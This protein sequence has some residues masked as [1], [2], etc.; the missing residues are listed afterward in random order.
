MTG[1]QE[2]SEQELRERLRKR[3]YLLEHGPGSHNL[4]GPG[5]RYNRHGISHNLND[6]TSSGRVL[7]G[8]TSKQVAAA[9]S[10]TS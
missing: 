10:S 8:D 2:P 9:D 6:A 4:K 5:K 1:R 3:M 7:K